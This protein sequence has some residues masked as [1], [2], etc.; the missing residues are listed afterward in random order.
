MQMSRCG[1][2]AKFKKLR[3]VKSVQFLFGWLS[4]ENRLLS[5]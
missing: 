5:P 1:G 3:E 2:Q 4:C